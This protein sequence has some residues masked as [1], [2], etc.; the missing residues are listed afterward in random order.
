MKKILLLSLCLVGCQTAPSNVSYIQREENPK[1]ET[2]VSKEEF[3]KKVSY[4]Y[5]PDIC[6][7]TDSL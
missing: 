5:R 4:S 3:S 1:K 7:T 2:C 6:L